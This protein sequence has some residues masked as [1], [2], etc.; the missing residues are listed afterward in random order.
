[1]ARAASPS[2][3]Y[4]D[5]YLGAASLLP[6]GDADAAHNDGGASVAMSVFDLAVVPPAD[7]SCGARLVRVRWDVTQQEHG[8]GD[9]VDECTV[10]DCELAPVAP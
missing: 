9:D 6:S 4:I 1:M 2:S 3:P 8:V 10:W 7:A 5:T